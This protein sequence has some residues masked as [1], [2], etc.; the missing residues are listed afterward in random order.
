M[1][2]FQASPPVGIPFSVR[3][4]A[5]AGVATLDLAAVDPDLRG[6]S[7]G[8]VVGRH[9][10]LVPYRNQDSLDGPVDLFG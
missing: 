9:L 10:Y 3:T 7:D 2:T 1:V 6:F 5:G 8:V 4:L